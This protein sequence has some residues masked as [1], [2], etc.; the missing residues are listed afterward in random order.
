MHLALHKRVF[1]QKFSQVSENRRIVAIME[2]V[3]PWLL[4]LLH[5]VLAAV[6]F[7]HDARARSTFD[8]IAFPAECS[9]AV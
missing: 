9:R 3:L 8:N 1:C 4:L 6:I 7:A 2:E 5:E